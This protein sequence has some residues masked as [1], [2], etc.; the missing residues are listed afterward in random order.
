MN[1]LYEIKDPLCHIASQF[2][3]LDTKLNVIK[4]QMNDITINVTNKDILKIIDYQDKL[5]KTYIEVLCKLYNYLLTKRFFYDIHKFG[6]I[7]TLNIDYYVLKDLRYNDIKKILR[8][9]IKE[10]EVEN[11]KIKELC[12]ITCGLV[13]SDK[14]INNDFLISILRNIKMSYKGYYENKKNNRKCNNWVNFFKKTKKK[15]PYHNMRNIANMWDIE[16]QKNNL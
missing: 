1:K 7:I 15:Y 2:M 5:K 3:T 13:I 10:L 11:N 6:R 12:N 4:A 9:I 16:K 8:S 14:D